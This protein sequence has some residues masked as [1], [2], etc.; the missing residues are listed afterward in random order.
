MTEHVYEMVYKWINIEDIEGIE[1][2]YGEE[3]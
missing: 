2:G 3:Y 1:I